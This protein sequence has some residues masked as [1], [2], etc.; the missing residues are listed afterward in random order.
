MRTLWKAEFFSFCLKQNYKLIHDAVSLFA[1]VP[2][3]LH[4]YYPYFTLQTLRSSSP[5]K[6]LALFSKTRLEL[7]SE[8]YFEGG[9]LEVLLWTQRCWKDYSC[10]ADTRWTKRSASC[11]VAFSLP[12]RCVFWVSLK[13]V[14]DGVSGLVLVR[15]VSP[16]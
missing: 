15:C 2:W 11:L 8:T 12:V 13:Q 4:I 10:D 5:R 6:F 14:L 16:T 1:D 3:E 7:F 9:V